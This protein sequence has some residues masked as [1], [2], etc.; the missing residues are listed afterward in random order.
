MNIQSKD[1]GFRKKHPARILGV[2]IL[3]LASAALAWVSPV[4]IASDVPHT[5]ES[6]LD[7]QT[8]SAIIDWLCLKMNEIYVFPDVAEKMEKHIRAKLNEGKYDSIADPR[9]FA[10]QLR[11]DLVA[12]SHDKHFNV[13]YG[14]SS[15][16]TCAKQPLTADQNSP[17]AM[18]TP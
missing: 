1:I 12:I 4:L 8:K 10:R 3:F 5:Q 11:A 17:A 7:S 13:V 18:I 2:L 16:L 15:G 14:K 9:A 6:R